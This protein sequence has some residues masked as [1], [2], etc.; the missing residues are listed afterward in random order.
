[1]CG[2]PSKTKDDTRGAVDNKKTIKYYVD[3]HITE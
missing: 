3:M 2:F 1:M